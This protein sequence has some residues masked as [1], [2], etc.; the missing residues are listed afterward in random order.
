MEIKNLITFLKI[1]EYESFTKAA[2]VLGYTQPTITFQLKQ[3]ESELQ[4]KLFD[5]LGNHIQITEAGTSLLDYA[6][7]IV[8]L[9]EEANHMITKKD[10]IP[11]LPLRITGVCSA[12]L[13]LLPEL[14]SQYHQ[15]YPNI[16]FEANT[17]CIDDI[18]L[19]LVNGST[20][21]GI[22]MDFS[23]SC[24]DFQIAYMETN[25]LY[26]ICA[27]NNPLA[28]MKSVDL[29]SL[30]T[31]PLIVTEKHCS[32]RT[33]F[34]EMMTKYNSNPNLVFESENTEIIKSFV[35]YD[36][37]ISLLPEIAVRKELE[38][39]KLCKIPVSIPLPVTYIKI[40]YHKNKWI[41]PVMSNF[42]ELLQGLG[43]HS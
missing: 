4:I 41:S 3:L 35:A 18:Y 9:A 29:Q 8:F 42:L 36:L 21:I 5:R 37:G 23:Q 13:G 7:H 11:L 24:N 27:P 39:N 25:P 26:F 10:S 16:R 40:V 12:C 6:K 2:S 17:A 28:S 14:I 32:Y 43:Q 19:K 34:M 31:L 20:D 38:E 22:I 15:K 1:A 30:A 33:L